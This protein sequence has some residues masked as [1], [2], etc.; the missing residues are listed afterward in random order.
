MTVSPFN[1]NDIASTLPPS[2]R[3][4]HVLTA[5]SRAAATTAGTAAG[6]SASTASSAGQISST[7][8]MDLLVAQL[9]NQ[10]PTNPVDPT[11]F[12][13]QLVQFNTL[14]QVM[15]INQDLTPAPS[16]TTTSNSA[17]TPTPTTTTAAA[18]ATN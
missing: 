9:Q 7:E 1:L 5:P 16:S 14:E 15:D 4:I 8:F 13:S 2:T 18:P 12:V 10:D 17:P 6:A 3:G 11:T